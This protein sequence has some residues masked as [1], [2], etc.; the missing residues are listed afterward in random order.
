MDPDNAKKAVE[1][2]RRYDKDSSVETLQ[3]ELAITRSLVQ[4]DAAIP[5]GFIDTAAWK[6]TEQIMVIQG[7][8]PTP[9][10]VERALRKILQQ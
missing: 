10:N 6:Q 2:L 8:V 4:P 7:L 9:V 5:I 1:T 3:Q